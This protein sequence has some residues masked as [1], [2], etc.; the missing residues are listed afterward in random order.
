MIKKTIKDTDPDVL[1][2]HLR[3]EI[4]DLVDSWILYKHFKLA[5]Q[6]LQ[7]DDIYADAQNKNLNFLYL[8]TDKF[9]DDLIARIAEL[10]DKKVGQLNF[11]LHSENLRFLRMR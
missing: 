6:K 7:T 4:G 11:L 2:S 1:I 9:R 8:V 5:S 3:A 10:G